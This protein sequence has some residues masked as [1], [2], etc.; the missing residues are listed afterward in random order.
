MGFTSGFGIA[1]AALILALAASPEMARAGNPGVTLDIAVS[2]LRSIH[3]NVLVCLTANPKFFP[4][5]DKD[6][7]GRKQ[8]V[9]ANQAGDIRFDDVQPQ[10]YAVSLI[11]D[12]NANNKMDLAIFMPKEG[13]GFSRNPRIGMGP[14]KFSSAAFSVG[15]KN[16]HLAVAMKY[17]F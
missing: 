17:M 15:A 12:E 14:P 13:F 6:P 10:T 11:H 1:S 4:N 5:C 2:G 7:A 16:E 8:R 3:G 9:A